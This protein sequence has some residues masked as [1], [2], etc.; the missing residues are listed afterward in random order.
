MPHVL[1]DGVRARNLDVLF[2]GASCA[3]RSHV[4][5]GVAACADDRRIAATAGQFEG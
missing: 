2:P 4:L 5:I 3:R 1:D